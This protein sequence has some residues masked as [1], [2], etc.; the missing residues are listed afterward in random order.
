MDR[1]IGENTMKIFILLSI[2]GLAILV[3]GSF[4]LLYSL[5]FWHT[6]GIISGVIS[7]LY[8][9]CFFWLANQCDINTTK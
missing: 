6:L 9:A 8:S 4:T 7:M 5:I 3:L 2:F 1:K